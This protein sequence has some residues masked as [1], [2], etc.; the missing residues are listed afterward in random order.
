MTGFDVCMI[1]VGICVATLAYLYWIAER[2][3][4][5]LQKELEWFSG[6]FSRLR[7]ENDGLRLCVTKCNFFTP[8]ATGLPVSTSS[9][10]NG[11]VGRDKKGRFV[12]L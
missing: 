3:L 12:K 1:I 4:R 7:A 11:K 6:Q 8:M 2:E 9:D 5:E 10:A